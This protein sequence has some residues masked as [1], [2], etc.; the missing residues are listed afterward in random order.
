M[1][2]SLIF[3]NFCVVTLNRTLDEITS[4]IEI[5]DDLLSSSDHDIDTFVKGVHFSNIT[6]I[7]NARIFI[8]FNVVMGL[9]SILLEL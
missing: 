4:F 9:K 5:F 1:D 7:A 2:Q 8:S 3:S 6:R